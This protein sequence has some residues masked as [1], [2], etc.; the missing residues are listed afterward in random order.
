VS[1][2]KSEPAAFAV[3][4]VLS[5][6]VSLAEFQLRQLALS[7]LGFAGELADAALEF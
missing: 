5:R 1:I 2:A 4:L 6:I 7:Q 3:P